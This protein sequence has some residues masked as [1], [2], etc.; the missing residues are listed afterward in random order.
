MKTMLIAGLLLL[1]VI[2]SKAQNSPSIPDSIDLHE[3]PG[4]WRD[5]GFPGGF[6]KLEEYIKNNLRQ[7]ANFETV[8]GRVIVQFTIEKDG[9]LTDI[10]VVR[11]LSPGCDKEAIRLIQGFPKWIP[12]MQNG[13]L[14]RTAYSI[15]ITFK[16]NN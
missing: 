15:P 14:V 6:K 16:L 7:S 2:G 3:K 5:V 8:E 11:G 1:L 13:I 9:S 10:R 4:V 12:A